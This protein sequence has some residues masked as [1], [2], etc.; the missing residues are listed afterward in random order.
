[1]VS[2]ENVDSQ[3]FTVFILPPK[4]QTRFKHP[5]KEEK[6]LALS[7]GFVFANTRKNTTWAYKVFLDWLSEKE[8]QRQ[9][10]VSRNLFLVRVLV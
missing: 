9:K 8:Q 1:M 4:K 5:S 7:K 3:E 6:V 10:T 2:R